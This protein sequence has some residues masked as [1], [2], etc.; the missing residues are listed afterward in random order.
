[1]KGTIHKCVEKLV[2]EKFGQEKW[3]ECLTAAGLDDDHVFMMNDDVD[4]KLTMELITKAPTV[5][6]ISLAQLFD[7]F[8]EYWVHT[9]A[10]KVYPA[11]Y[12]GVSSSKEFLLKL[13]N[14]HVE[15]TQNVSNA[16]PPMFDYVWEGSNI[17]KMTYKSGRG[18][19]DLF[20][21]LAKG[22][23]SYYKDNVKIE[24]PEGSNTV[25]FTFS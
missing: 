6:G 11:Y 18:L 8:G 1:M 7:A 13:Q 2:I 23:S 22:L 4:E 25:V 12:E 19:V 14:I 9:Y 21:S 24:K 15:I 16:R 5:L 3:E 20:V 17:L 10:P